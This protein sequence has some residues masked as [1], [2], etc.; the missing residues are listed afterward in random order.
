MIRQ[1]KRNIPFHSSGSCCR[2]SIHWSSRLC[3]DIDLF[4]LKLSYCNNLPQD[5]CPI[6]FAISG[7]FHQDKFPL[8]F[9]HRDKKSY[10]VSE[11]CATLQPMRT[12]AVTFHCLMVIFQGNPFT[13]SCLHNV[14]HFVLGSSELMGSCFSGWYMALSVSLMCI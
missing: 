8:F 2:Y 10:W 14:D 11:K 3:A 4:K 6:N 9:L 12:N 5:I 13:K 7:P 1:K